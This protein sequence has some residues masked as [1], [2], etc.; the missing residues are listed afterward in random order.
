MRN[1]IFGAIG[2]VWGGLML[3]S[4]F[5]RGEPQGSGSYAAGQNAALVFAVLLVLVGGYYLL[6][7]GQKSGK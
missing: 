4:A 7:G 2:V 1:R 6:K 5:L 3:L